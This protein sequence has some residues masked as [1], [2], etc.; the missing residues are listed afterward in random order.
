MFIEQLLCASTIL[1]CRDVD[2]V[3]II[4]VFV[5]YQKEKHQIGS[6]LYKEAG[7]VTYALWTTGVGIQIKNDAWK[8]LGTVPNSPQTS[9]NCSLRFLFLMVKT[10]SNNFI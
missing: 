10:N 9:K 8:L 7:I 1:D 5:F 3:S 4:I 2:K 6:N